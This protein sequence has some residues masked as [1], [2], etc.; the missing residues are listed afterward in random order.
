MKLSQYFL[1]QPTRELALGV[2][3]NRSWHFRPAEVIHISYRYHTKVLFA[4][5][6]Q[7]LV[8]SRLRDFTGRDVDWMGLRIYVTVARLKEAIQQHRCILAAEAPEFDLLNGVAHSPD[9]RDHDSCS[10]DWHATWWNG[11]GRF[12]LDGRNPLTWTDA[13]QQFEHLNFGEM[14][15][16]C[17]MNMLDVVRTEDSNSHVYQMIDRV[18]EELMAGI[19]EIVH[20]EE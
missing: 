18:S 12:L 20:G 17:L 3:R 19:E 10:R 1:S 14:N 2:M 8:T 11:M 7:R 5:A 16:T 13:M 9:C 4:V 15:P 6:F